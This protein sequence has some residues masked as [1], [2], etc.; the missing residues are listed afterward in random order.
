MKTIESFG[1]RPI[2]SRG[3]S[4]GKYNICLL[5]VMADLQPY[6]FEPECVSNPQDSES[7][8]E[9]VNDRLESTFGVLVRD[10]KSCQ[11][12]ENVFV[13]DNSQRKK[14]KFKV[15]F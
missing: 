9:E 8:N 12:K 3:L 13:A 11:R 15:K 7:E 1:V 4:M 6:H 5:K 10:V 2:R 14:T